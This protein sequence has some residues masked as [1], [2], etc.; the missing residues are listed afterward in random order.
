VNEATGEPPDPPTEAE[1]EADRAFTEALYGACK[2]HEF[3]RGGGVEMEGDVLME[4]GTCRNCSKPMRRARK[5][6]TA[7]ARNEPSW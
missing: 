4:L 3:V 1:L 7:P 2:E 6:V 5:E